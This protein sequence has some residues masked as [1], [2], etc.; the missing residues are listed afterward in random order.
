MRTQ[1]L[2]ECLREAWQIVRGFAGER[3]YENYLAH[4]SVHHPD[5]PVLTERAFWRAHVDRGDRA[6]TARCC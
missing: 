4:Q 3:A 5:E 1:R 2:R 6:A